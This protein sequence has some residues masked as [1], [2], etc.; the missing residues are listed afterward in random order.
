MITLHHRPDFID[1]LIL[2]YSL[3]VLGALIVTLI[4]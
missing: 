3:S 1:S 4:E 2:D